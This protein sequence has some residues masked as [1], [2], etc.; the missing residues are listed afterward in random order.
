[1]MF[2]TSCFGCWLYLSHVDKAARIYL[3]PCVKPIQYVWCTKP[4]TVPYSC[5]MTLYDFWHFDKFILVLLRLSTAEY[6]IIP[7]SALTSWML[8]SGG[9]SFFKVLSKQRC[10][11]LGWGS[12][13]CF[14][15]LGVCPL[16]GKERDVKRS[17]A[18]CLNSV[19]QYVNNGS[20]INE[21][22]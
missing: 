13:L 10:L 6:L 8:L 14:T 15:F 7:V 16:Q 9:F 11:H 19:C 5:S 18:S 22:N 2:I 20:N 1:M 17:K 21:L 12:A 4:L 3:N